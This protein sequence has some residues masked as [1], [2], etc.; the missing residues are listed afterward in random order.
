M[1]ILV[2]QYAFIQVLRGRR[3]GLKVSVLDSGSRG[4]GSR[5]GLCHIVVFLGKLQ[6][7]LSECTLS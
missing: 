6:P 1:I 4:P 3:G 7:K 5:A 2:R